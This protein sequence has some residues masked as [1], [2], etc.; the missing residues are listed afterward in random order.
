MKWHPHDYGVEIYRELD[1]ARLATLS[2]AEAEEA[3]EAESLAGNQM[4]SDLRGFTWADVAKAIAIERAVITRLQQA[5]DLETEAENWDEERHQATEFEDE[6]WS[7]D[8]GVAAATIV[9]S[10]MGATPVGS[11]N[12]GGFGGQ[13]QAS[14]PYV[15]FFASPDAADDI[16]GIATAADVGLVVGDDGIARIYGRSDLDLL[17]FAETAIALRCE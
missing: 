5:D 16:L 3:G 2:P 4:Y 13:H 12:A 9:L 7:L 11:C 1:R 14:H 17:H 6:L 10:A 8:V 15:A